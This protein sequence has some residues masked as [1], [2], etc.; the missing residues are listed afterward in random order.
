MTYETFTPPPVRKRKGPKRPKLFTMGTKTNPDPYQPNQRL[1]VSISNGMNFLP[2]FPKPGAKENER[3]TRIPNNVSVVYKGFVETTVG[4]K[5]F[6]ISYNDIE[7]YVGI[8]AKKFLVPLRK[9][10]RL[11]KK[12]R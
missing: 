4:T 3:I 9:R 11:S 10:Q 5:V 12:Y 6:C 1:V 8:A 7:V 2:C